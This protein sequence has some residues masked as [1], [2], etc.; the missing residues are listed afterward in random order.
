MRE[1]QSLPVVLTVLQVLAVTSAVVIVLKAAQRRH[2]R[3]V[4]AVIASGA[5]LHPATLY[6]SLWDVH[7]NVLGLPLFVAFLF[8]VASQRG[9]PALAFGLLSIGV[10]ED[11]A[12]LVVL[13]AL[14]NWRRLDRLATSTLVV[15]GITAPAIWATAAGNAGAVSIFGFVDLSDLMGTLRHALANLT[16]GG[17]ALSLVTLLGLPWVFLP[18]PDWRI[19]LP[20][21]L[22]HAALLVSDT[23]VT[24][25]IG[26]HYYIVPT[27][28]IAIAIALRPVA[29]ADAPKQP[30]VL[31]QPT[32][33][34]AAVVS[35]VL[36]LIVG[37]LGT[38]I[39]SR[40]Y[41]RNSIVGLLEAHDSS[42][43]LAADMR[44][45]VRCV[46]LNEPSGV[47]AV[48]G[49]YVP[50]LLGADLRVLPHPF[51]DYLFASGR[52]EVVLL[53]ADET[54]PIALLILPSTPIPVGYHQDPKVRLVYW[55]EGGPGHCDS[56]D[57]A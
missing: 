14:V 40:E 26:F 32:R 44:L 12:L 52:S 48:E 23:P 3:V 16:Q 13:V 25:S 2:T 35:L 8:F 4:A 45:A 31:S 36:L 41:T 9:V 15:A 10:R 21:V 47:I 39:V 22:P 46:E 49:E 19:A 30:P 11:I 5:A 54:V 37:P 50:W 33:R 20:V 34:F 57:A 1:L 7:M 29:D 56:G 17:F 53:P 43:A 28:A 18:K 42:K 27:F 51:D 6:G 38:S 55:H 24:R